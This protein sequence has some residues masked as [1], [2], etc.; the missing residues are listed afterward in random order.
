MEKELKFEFDTI[1]LDY[2]YLLE[3]LN[4]NT[5]TQKYK[6]Y[7][8][9][10][11]NSNFL[12]CYQ[13]IKELVLNN[14][15]KVIISKGEHFIKSFYIYSSLDIK[16]ICKKN[17]INI[18]TLYFTNDIIYD[19]SNPSNI[20]N[21]IENNEIKFILKK[22][23]KLPEPHLL[24][25][26][27][28]KN[29]YTYKEYSSF[30]N[31]YFGEDINPTEIFLYENNS[32][33]KKIFDNLYKLQY[34]ND[35]N[36]FKFTGPY[37]IGKS[38]TLLQYCRQNENAFYINI[39]ILKKI[40]EFESYSII[41]EEFSR[42]PN[43]LFVEVQ[44]LIE[45]KYN[46]GLDIIEAIFSIIDYLSQI[47]LNFLFV[48]DQYKIKYFPINLDFRMEKLDKKIKIVLCSSINDDVM[49]EECLKTWIEIGNPTELSINNQ[50][51]FFY[52]G[53]IYLKR[54]KKDQFNGISK[55]KKMYDAYPKQ[56]AI[57]K[58]NQHI[59]EKLKDYCDK[60]KLSLDF[61]LVNV[62]N[63]LNKEYKIT[64]LSEVIR[65]CPL[66]FFVVEF[67]ENEY[68]KIKKR[69]PFLNY[70]INT[71]LTNIEVDNYFKQKKYAHLTIEND[72]VKGD[73]FEYSVKFGLKNNIILPAEINDEVVLEEIITMNKK[74]DLSDLEKES[75]MEIEDNDSDNNIIENNNKSIDS[76]SIE[77]DEDVNENDELKEIN[78][79]ETTSASN[80]DNNLDLLMKKF[81]INL[82]NKINDKNCLEYYRKE[83]ILKANKNK[84][85]IS[86]KNQ[87]DGNKNYFINQT[88]R[89][90]RMLDYA[91]LFGDRL[92]KHFVGFQIKCYFK[93]S[94]SINDKFVNKQKI[95]KKCQKILL[96]SMALF[97]CKITNWYY[98]L[99]F[100][101]NKNNPDYNVN[102]SI[103]KK[104]RGT[105]EILFY[106]P[107]EKKFY[108]INKKHLEKLDLNF[109]SNLDNYMVTYSMFT[110]DKSDI[111]KIDIPQPFDRSKLEQSFL[112]DLSFFKKNN[113]VDILK[114]IRDI[115]DIK[116]NLVLKYKLKVIKHINFPPMENFVFLYKKIRA[117]F[118]GVKSVFEKSQGFRK[119]KYYDLLEKKEIDNFFNVL[120]LECDYL[121]SLYIKRHHLCL[122]GI[123]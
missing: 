78:N 65:F 3:L 14:K 51:Y 49:R 10:K 2:S 29:S 117:G 42:I 69:F 40:R 88:K 48:F 79:Y 23:K 71:K 47:N 7:N 50:K 99:I 107:V 56:T 92:K 55:Y 41:R 83:E 102:E 1:N 74:E 64:N 59:S 114:E 115:M 38:T 94:T 31:Y 82:K 86:L 87:F 39:K 98:Y 20:V 72:S 54:D 116:G 104:C 9:V 53:N 119:A 112:E 111:F 60:I 105:I 33:R 109:N 62:K 85:K 13:N 80:N 36:R 28:D 67:K 45:D 21:H 24:L 113:F 97:D 70:V 34:S 73:Y 91:L 118:I 76:M 27:S 110:I 68:F 11:I 5:F 19:K 22:K 43:N 90:G 18:N 75:D 100:Y 96:N 84:E 16:K 61:V 52:Y 77:V 89:K 57:S 63:M 103:I 122:E 123:E 81:S 121:Y 58:V 4:N 25:A 120:D 101:Y 108:D 15:T 37:S 6:F 26:F 12:I 35:I 95:K 93:N 66:K 106:E 46:N 30:Y 32:V 8:V 17:N 44:K